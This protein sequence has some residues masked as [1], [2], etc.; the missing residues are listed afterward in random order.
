MNRQL[1]IT[2]TCAALVAADACAQRRRRGAEPT[3]EHFT[4]RTV[5]FESSALGGR[6]ASYRVYLPIDYDDEANAERDYPLVVWLHGLW[7]NQDRFHVRGG[8]EVLERMRAADEI[9]DLVFV[10]ANGGNSFYIDGPDEKQGYET[11]IVDDLLDHLQK[12]YRISKDRGSRAITGV[13][14]G[15]NGALKIAL[16]HPDKFG[17]VAAHSAALLPRDPDDLEKQ[18]PWIERRGGAKRA[19]APIFGDP[20]DREKWDAENVLHLAETVEPE[21]LE[22]LKIYFDCGDADDYGF[23]APNVELEKIL[24]KRKI[25]HTWRSVEGGDHGWSYNQRALPESLRFIRAGLSVKRATAGLG[26]LFG[27]N[28]E[29]SSEKEEPK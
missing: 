27:G 23:Y 13:S 21:Q 1:L 10:C 6:E 24:E 26:G 9:P 15:G 16:K 18:F 3:L 8:A 2:L 7:E 29:S 12:T 14:M 5:S 19:M 11:M 22:G 4:T 25:R 28:A 17:I 20:L